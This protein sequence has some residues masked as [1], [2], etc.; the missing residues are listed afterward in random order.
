MPPDPHG[1]TS[2]YQT[3]TKFNLVVNDYIA[4]A[5]P[6]WVWYT[7]VPQRN[8]Y[9][10][11]PGRPIY[12]NLKMWLHRYHQDLA[13]W[14]SGVSDDDGPDLWV[15]N[16]LFN[17]VE[18]LKDVAWEKVETVL[19]HAREVGWQGPGSEQWIEMDSKDEEMYM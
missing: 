16:C 1:G 8:V 14:M 7:G 5:K 17:I 13:K 6:Y 12:P 4:P 2:I 11:L 19:I 9:I 10:Q 3:E 18:T 15:I